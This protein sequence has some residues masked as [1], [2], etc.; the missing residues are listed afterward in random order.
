MLRFTLRRVLQIIPTVVVVALLI[1]VIF[2][3]VPGTFA[4]S[5]FADGRRA[6]DPQMIARLNEEFGLNKPLMERFVTYVTDLAQ[7]DLGTS[8]RT[9]QPVIDLIN[10]RMWASLQLAI[11]AMIFALVISVPLGFVAALRPG[12]VLDTVT[13]IGAVS[14]LSMPQFWL[15]L[16]MMYLFALQLNWLPSFGYGDGSFRNLI[17][18]AVTL[19]VTPLALLARTT[20]AGVLDVLNADFIRTAHSKGMS[21]AKVVRWH[22]ARN[23]LVL[24]VTTVGLQFGSLI[25][26]AV[27]IEK[28][29]AW[30][31]IGSLLVDSVASRDIPVVQG[32]IF[33]IVLWFLV[34][35]TA[36]DLIY[37]AIDPRIKQE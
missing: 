28:L 27:V 20:R 29:F 17:L 9:R 36:V 12:S 3:V 13:M 22:V 21:E 15:G 37:A 24:I 2:S 8:F 33:V 34:I 32:T 6:A 18:P 19:G 7:F 16:L 25:G 31:G 4:A 35:N 14:G 26:Q 30:P 11:A 1:F 23:A 5:L 10:D